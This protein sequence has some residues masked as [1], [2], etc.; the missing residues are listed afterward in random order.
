MTQEEKMAQEEK[1]NSE[2]TKAKVAEVIA[3][4]QRNGLNAEQ[5]GVWIWVSFDE[6]PG[7]ATRR[8][9][10]SAGFRWSRRRSKWAHNVGVETKSSKGNPWDKYDHRFV[11]RRIAS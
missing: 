11:S 6:N 5:V 7:D 4:C 3:F 1:M 2:E 8:L 10:K 9:L